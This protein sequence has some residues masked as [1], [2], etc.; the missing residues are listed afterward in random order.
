[1]QKFI[2]FVILGIFT[3]CNKNVL[4]DVEHPALPV[5]PKIIIYSSRFTS[6]T[7]APY[8]IALYENANGF[9]IFPHLP[10]IDLM[11]DN[12]RYYFQ[13]DSLGTDLRYPVNLINGTN[14]SN[15]IFIK[16]TSKFFVRA[17]HLGNIYENFLS[18]ICKYN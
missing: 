10:N 17:L 16:N 7:S 15:S 11:Q 5:Q 9:Q 6:P 2:K 4:A 14:Y 8:M 13:Y 12:V 1:M 3:L 18:V